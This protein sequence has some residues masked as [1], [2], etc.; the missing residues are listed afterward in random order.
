MTKISFIFQE[1]VRGYLE[2]EVARFECHPLRFGMI[3][4]I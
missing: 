4:N 2:K 1:T 3:P